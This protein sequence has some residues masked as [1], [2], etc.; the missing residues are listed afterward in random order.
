MESWLFLEH[1]AHDPSWNMACDEWLLKNVK[2]FAKPVLRTYGWDRPSM[3]IGYFQSFPKKVPAGYKIIRRPTGGALVNHDS[4]LTFTVV[5]PSTHSWFQVGVCERYQRV[6]ER[7][8]RVFTS[9][10]AQSVL[11]STCAPS[12]SGRSSVDTLCFAKSSR[13][14]VLVQGIKVAGGAQRVTRDGL[15]HQG[16][17]QGG[18]HPQV[19]SEE[20]RLAWEFFGD[21]CEPF[22][23]TESQEKEITQLAKQKFETVEWNQQR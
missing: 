11:A 19:S 3:T 4:D 9:R 5:L 22:H 16:S 8:A 13:Y 7:V 15:I 18:Q 17:I 2:D 21:H 12:P 6:H 20:M 10:G 14:D 23:L 1:A